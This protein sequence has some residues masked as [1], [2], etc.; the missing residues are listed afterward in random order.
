MTEMVSLVKCCFMLRRLIAV[1]RGYP[2]DRRMQLYREILDTHYPHYHSGFTSIEII[3]EVNFVQSRLQAQMGIEG[4]EAYPFSREVRLHQHESPLY[5]IY[6][7]AL[8]E[9]EVLLLIRNTFPDSLDVFADIQKFINPELVEANLPI[10]EVLQ[11][12]LNYL[13]AVP[14][15]SPVVTRQQIE[16]ILKSTEQLCSDSSNENRKRITEMEL[17]TASLFLKSPSMDKKLWALSLI[18]DK[19]RLLGMGDKYAGIELPDFLNW[20]DSSGIYLSLIQ[21]NVHPE[22]M[23]RS[24]QLVRFLYEKERL[25]ISD[26]EDLVQFSIRSESDEIGKLA[27]NLIIK[28]EYKHLEKVFDLL[29]AIE[30]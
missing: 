1:T 21:Q 28:L 6:V 15:D 27:H 13:L 14:N 30:A 26:I 5:Q 10:D 23:A 11:R 19:I 18:N 29:I 25:T 24:N 7:G 16:H 20:L 3:N 9:V 12:V 17:Y 22:V 4:P 2:Q 8:L